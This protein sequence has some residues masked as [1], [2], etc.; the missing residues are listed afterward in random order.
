M[1][2]RP[3][4]RG[5]VALALL[6]APATAFA[7]GA[8]VYQSGTIA[9]HRLLKA[10]GNGMQMDAG[11]TTGDANGRGVAPFSVS[12]AL[13]TGLCFNSAATSGQYNGLCV[14][15]DSSGNGLITLDSFGG[16]VDKALKFRINGTEYDFPASGAGSGDVV[17]PNSSTVNHIAFFNNTTGT[18]LKDNSWLDN[19]TRLLAPSGRTI[20]LQGAGV[21]Q[22]HGTDGVS[23]FAIPGYPDTLNF[24]AQVGALPSTDTTNV[25]IFPPALGEQ[26]YLSVAN[27]V[28]APAEERVLLG[29]NGTGS[30]VL[31]A[32]ATGGGTSRPICVGDGLGASTLCFQPRS[33]GGKPF[34]QLGTEVPLVGGTA[35]LGDQELLKLDSNTDLVV[36]SGG[37]I[38]KIIFNKH[39]NHSGSAPTLSSCGGGTPTLTV[40]TDVKGYVTAGTGSVTACTVTYNAAYDTAPVVVITGL[41][42]GSTIL[43]LSASTTTGFTVAASA[44]IEGQSFTYHVIE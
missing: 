32:L 35:S 9:P 41:G 17:G 36:A 43:S 22:V 23:M 11:G 33:G 20:T 21:F 29:Y 7:Q 42:T 19:G 15:H 26:A 25:Q 6:L 31:Q 24:Q 2:L 5:I 12:D 16:L 27:S 37:N 30:Y 18:L 44:S 8:P 38:G 1:N 28:A 4:R 13:G 34:V 39:L 3:I 14:G 40:A 10:A